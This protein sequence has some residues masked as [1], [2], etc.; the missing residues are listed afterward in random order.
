MTFANI[1]IYLALIAFIIARRFKGRPI[2]APKRLFALPVILII[3]GYGDLSQGTM[4]PVEVT[5]TVIGAALSL[6]LGLLRGRADKITSRD[7]SP[8]VQWSAAS[9]IL[10]IATLAAKLVLDLIGVAAGSTAAAAEKSLLFTFGLTLAGEAIVLFVRSGQV[11][12]LHSQPSGNLDYA[13]TGAPASGRYAG[14]PAS[15]AL[16]SSF[17]DML[18]R[19]GETARQDERPARLSAAEERQLR[20]LTERARASGLQRADE[21]EL[22]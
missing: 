7:G 6:S 11:G 16:D 5:L 19:T 12:L 4:K 20:E 9:L 22:R 8:F 18:P 3:L 21:G 17:N 15:S 1:L 13:E 2:G 10:F 14:V